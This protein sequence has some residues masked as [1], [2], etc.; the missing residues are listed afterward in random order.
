MR[1]CARGL[2]PRVIDNSATRSI[3]RRIIET[4][5]RRRLDFRAPPR[6]TG[7][8]RDST[9]RRCLGKGW[10]LSYASEKVTE[11]VKPRQINRPA[12]AC[13]VEQ[14]GQTNL[15]VGA[16]R[17]GAELELV[18]AFHARN[19]S[20]LLAL[21]VCPWVEP[22]GRS[23]GGDARECSGVANLKQVKIKAVSS[24]EVAS[25]NNSLS[26]TDDRKT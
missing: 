2:T 26:L 23:A 5:S 17:R 7:R 25:A 12:V 14:A 20:L 24:V 10:P 3:V 15:H 13:P 22:D 8:F 21:V 6:A 16:G 1:W 19:N 11:V 9:I 4:C 18:E